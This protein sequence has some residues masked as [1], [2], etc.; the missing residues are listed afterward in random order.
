MTIEELESFLEN[1][2]QIE[3]MIDEEN[4]IYLRHGHYDKEQEKLKIEPKAL[5]EL[6]VEK[7][8]KIL[9]GGRDIE[10]ITR[11]TGYFSRVSGWNKGKKG[12]LSERNRVSLN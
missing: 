10:H 2:E 11:V 9:V 12:E 7:L 4:N 6:T 1:N 3:W 8:E 5:K